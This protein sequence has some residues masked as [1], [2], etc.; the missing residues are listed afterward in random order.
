MPKERVTLEEAGRLLGGLHPNTV[1][2]RAV[3]GKYEY[4]KDNTGKWFVW[5]DTDAAAN[6]RAER[7]QRKATKTQLEV[8]I[9]PPLEPTIVSG[10]KVL[11]VTIEVLTKELEAIRGDRDTLKAERDA[12]AAQLA[13]R[14]VI[15]QRLELALATIET[16]HEAAAG[17]VERLRQRLDKETDENRATLVNF[18]ERM[19]T[20]AAPAPADRPE[21]TPGLWGRLR[22]VATGR[23]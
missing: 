4:D 5:I 15:S 11:E 3:K 16:Q 23:R 22:Y 18:I 7:E 20:K 12:M 6:D 1:R 2:A 21:A 17:E 19:A 9:D 8:L 10:F 14:I 13:E